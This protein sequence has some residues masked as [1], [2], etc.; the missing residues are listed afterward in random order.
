MTLMNSVIK[1]TSASLGE[2]LAEG[3]VIIPNIIFAGLL[4]QHYGQYHFLL[5][6]V[7]LYSFEKAGVFAIQGFGELKNPYNP[8]NIAQ[9]YY[10]RKGSLS[11]E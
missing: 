1:N 8:Y 4:Y 7:L 3:A 5:P 9:Y 10:K 2:A 6:F 11:Y